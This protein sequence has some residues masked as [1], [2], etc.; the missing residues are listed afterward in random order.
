MRLDEDLGRHG[1]FRVRLEGDPAKAVLRLEI[2]R[3]ALLFMTAEGAGKFA[4]AVLIAL[5]AAGLREPGRTAEALDAAGVT[6]A[7]LMGTMGIAEN[8]VVVESAPP[9]PEQGEARI[10][11]GTAGAFCLR[12]AKPRNR[13]AL[14]ARCA[15]CG[16]AR[17]A[18]AIR[19][20]GAWISW[21]PATMLDL[22]TEGPP[23]EPT[24]RW[25]KVAGDA[26]RW[27][28]RGIDSRVL[29]G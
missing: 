1:P 20:D 29:G 10:D 5:V 21:P 24:A 15:G 12:G 8:G 25:M 4:E 14:R 19:Q 13:E 11:P 17:C 28:L 26:V 16:R 23:T 3:T 7:L 2:P 9:E 6:R 27:I 18:L 22:L